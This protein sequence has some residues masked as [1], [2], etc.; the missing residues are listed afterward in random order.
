MNLVKWAI[1]CLC[2]SI[3][4]YATSGFATAVLVEK[5]GAAIEGNPIF[6]TLF[7]KTN[8]IPLSLATVAVPLFASFAAVLFYLYRTRRIFSF[9]MTAHFLLIAFLFMALDDCSYLITDEQ[10]PLLFVQFVG[11]LYPFS[12][13][14]FIGLSIVFTSLVRP[15]VKNK[16][17]KK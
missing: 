15:F 7:E 2:L 8:N 14:I 10:N 12:C 16:R 11:I 17:I 13:L 3:I 5:R 9:L 6:R 1:I 4:F